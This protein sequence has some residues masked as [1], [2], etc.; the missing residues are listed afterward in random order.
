LSPSLLPPPFRVVDESP[1]W[2]VVDKPANL[3]V[4]PS[5]P[6]PLPTLWHELRRLLAFEIVCGGQI[7]II[8]RLDR[9]TSGL[10]LI[11]KD[12]ATASA[13]SKLMEARRIHKEYLALVWDWP[14]QDDWTVDAPLLRQGEHIV[15]RIYLKQMIHPQGA[16]AKTHFRVEHRFTRGAERFAVVRAWP[17]TGRLHQ[18]RVHLAH[19]GHAVVGDKLYGPDEGCYLEFIDTGWTESLSRRLLLKRHALH[20]A[21]LQLEEPL[22]EWRTG[23]PEDLAGFQRGS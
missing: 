20:S 17:Q 9:D 6:S 13:F 16:S 22:L 23:L 2:I 21:S 8:N 1:H 11:A 4:H 7:S 5:K 19:S 14:A 15:S 18:I 12:R 10:T 3:L